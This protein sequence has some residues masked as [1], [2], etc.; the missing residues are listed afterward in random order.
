MS[1]LP[2]THVDKEA[3]RLAIAALLHDVGK[4]VQHAGVQISP[5]IAALEKQL[6]PPDERG[7]PA[8]RHVLYT[9]MTISEAH[10]QFF[11]GLDRDALIRLA[12]GHHHP[13]AGQRDQ[14]ILAKA[15]LLASGHDR[16]PV[17]NIAHQ[18][19]IGLRPVLASVHLPGRSAVNV[20][21]HLPPKPLDFDAE[22]FLPGEPAD[23]SAMQQRCRDIADALRRAVQSPAADLPQCVERLL[24]ISAR[25]LC[26]V[27][28]GRMR[29]ADVSL[30]DHSRTVAAFAACLA[31]QHSGSAADAAKISGRYR[32]VC[33]ALGSIQKFIFR[34][35]PDL[36]ASPAESGERGMARRLRA[37]SF[38][39]S[40]LSY[41][42]AR[43]I[44]DTTGMP[45]VNL[46]L[47]AGGRSLI[48]LP[49]APAVLDRLR[50]A[51]A[52][53]RWW[54]EKH[55]LGAV[56]LDLAVSAPL[57]DAAFEAQRFPETYRRTD[58][59]LARA[60]LA[61]PAEHLR[62]DDHWADD[63]WVDPHASLPI[64]RAPFIASMQRLGKALP[65]ARFL[66]LDSSESGLLNTPLDILGYRVQLHDKQPSSGRFFALR[67]DP[68]MDCAI[69]LFIT[70]NHIPFPSDSDLQRL[71]QGASSDASGADDNEDD[72]PRKD[73]PL[74][75]NHLA[76]LAGD[77]NG[78]V[79]PH[80]MLGV[81][82]ADVDRLGMV[83]GR[84]LEKDV[85][86]GRVAGL[87]RGLDLFFKGFLTE[88][89]RRC[90]QHVYTVFGGGDDLLLIGPWYDIL[91]LAG[92]LYGWF[93][94]MVC[95]NPSLTFSAG[96]IF[97]APGTPARHLGY[98][99]E[100][101]LEKS[102]KAG[103]N[104]ITVG[105]TTLTWE[106]FRQSLDLHREMLALADDRQR[107]DCGLNSSLLYRIFQCANMGLRRKW[108]GDLKWRAQLSYDI[109]RNLP[110]EQR[111]DRLREQLMKA[112]ESPAV[113]RT[114]AMITLYC[115]R[116]G[117]V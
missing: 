43:R 10:Q 15:D 25:L 49:D 27:P 92:D 91:R 64:D 101:A 36:D 114:A 66:S 5:D 8:H 99:G 112:A 67:L 7:Q 65:M 63:G 2:Q 78:R 106:Q 94:R 17:E 35:V 29:Q 42:V 54:F 57:D 12:A 37:R 59:L 86:F 72:A 85:S 117:S 84:G 31:A 116:G 16:R 19:L 18:S 22:A 95:D 20:D 47:D 103:R 41:L 98:L 38:Y 1:S 109:R 21:K 26:G 4:V 69:P 53:I 105:S 32:L 90:Y 28:A 52:Y 68:A 56:R 11:A 104:R 115:T 82:K 30:H 111:F 74:T 60:R 113:L 50:S 33:I 48:L 23:T 81:L 77:G 45:L 61:V 6:C 89:L 40:L 51:V 107:R 13:D 100:E 55:L 39:I 108:P 87:S 96:V 110:D 62:P 70:A 83:L 93:C 80:A 73:A 75:F 71:Q 88:Q 76:A 102:K 79:F 97:A 44:L 24:A 34:F 9:A 3:H 58:S 14:H 46:M